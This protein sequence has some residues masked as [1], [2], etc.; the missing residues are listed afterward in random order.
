MR[1]PPNLSDPL[2]MERIQPEHAVWIV[3]RNGK[4]LL[5][6]APS[7]AAGLWAQNS[8]LEPVRRFELSPAELLRIDHKVCSA[9]RIIPSVFF[10]ARQ[11]RVFSDRKGTASLAMVLEAEWGEDVKLYI[12]DPSERDLINTL[13]EWDSRFNQLLLLDADTAIEA[14][15][16]HIESLHRARLDLTAD[17]L[18]ENT[19]NCRSNAM[20]Y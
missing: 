6:S 18:E 4:D 14:A 2:T 9:G 20:F 16:Q 10:A 8:V 3:G 17:I 13:G 12:Q 19:I 7:L 15:M 1:L 5:F 11:P